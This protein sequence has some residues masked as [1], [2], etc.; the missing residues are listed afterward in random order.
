MNAKTGL[1]LIFLM[2]TLVL[3]SAIISGVGTLQEEH[4]IDWS[5]V[6]FCFWFTLFLT[7]FGY[8][9]GKLDNED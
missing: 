7:G 4:I 2:P 6:V 8:V 3:T 1:F 9:I 5:Q